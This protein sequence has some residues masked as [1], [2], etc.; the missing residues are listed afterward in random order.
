[1]GFRRF[2]VGVGCLPTTLGLLT[3]EP[4]ADAF[5]A[6]V[7]NAFEK[8]PGGHFVEDRFPLELE[9]RGELGDSEIFPGHCLSRLSFN[10]IS[11]P[12][13]CSSGARSVAAFFRIQWVN[14]HL[15]SQKRRA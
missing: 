11:H 4:W 15:R 1:L 14:R 10:R 2:A 7:M 9:P 5:G 13:D 6:E 12:R 3:T 8:D